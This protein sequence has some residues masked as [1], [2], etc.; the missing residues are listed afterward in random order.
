MWDDDMIVDRSYILFHGMTEDRFRSTYPGKKYI[1]DL[2]T[3]YYHSQ[4]GW[5]LDLFGR[6]GLEFDELWVSR[7]RAPYI[8]PWHS[9]PGSGLCHGIQC[10]LV[11]LVFFSQQG[12]SPSRS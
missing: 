6:Q 12:P 5:L 8:R 11:P 1:F 4:L 9:G 10:L 7:G 2:G 3:N